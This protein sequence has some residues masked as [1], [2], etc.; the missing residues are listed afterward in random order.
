MID[1]KSEAVKISKL[2]GGK[3]HSR[4]PSPKSQYPRPPPPPRQQ[5]HTWPPPPLDAWSHSSN[6]W[7]PT[8]TVSI[9]ALF[10]NPRKL[11]EVR[12]GRQRGVQ[13]TSEYISLLYSD[14][15]LFGENMTTLVPLYDHPGHP[16]HFAYNYKARDLENK[17][18]FTLL[19][20][21]LYKPYLS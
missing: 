21:I 3:S 17:P 14:S 5:T 20:L 15:P 16:H 13:S 18:C 4:Y 10:I 9:I 6:L 11:A 1:G 8:A 7:T 12:T 19:Y 2:G